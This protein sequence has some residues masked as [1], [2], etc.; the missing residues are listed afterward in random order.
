MKKTAAWCL[1]VKLGTGRD[2]V[3]RRVASTAKRARKREK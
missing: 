2:E 3:E 1:K